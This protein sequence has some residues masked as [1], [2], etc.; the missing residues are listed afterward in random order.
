LSADPLRIGRAVSDG[1]TVMEYPLTELKGRLDELPDE[2]GCYVFKRRGKPLYVG[3]AKSLRK[4]VGQYFS[5]RSSGDPKAAAMLERATELELILTANETEALLLEMNLINKYRP[6]YNVSIH[7]FPYIKI[8]KEK[9]PR[10]FVTREGHDVRTGRYVGPFTDASAV[11][12]TVALT[13]RAFGLRTCAYDLDRNPP[14]RPCLD[15]EIGICLGPC[16]DA[17]TLE[18]YAV[19]VEKALKFITGR[20]SGVMRELEHRMAKAAA[21]L[22][23]EEAAKWRDVIKGLDRAVADQHAVAQRNVNADATACEVRA[24]KL[25]GVILRIREGKLVD[26]VTVATDAPAGNALEQFLLS[27]YG[28]GAEVPPKITVTRNFPGRNALAPSLAEKRGGTVA[29]FVPRWGEYAHLTNVAEKNL[30]YFIEAAEFSKARR[31]ELAAVFEE[32]AAATGAAEPPRRLEMVDIS[33]LGPKSV[34][35]SLVVFGGGIPDKNSYRRYRV[36]TISGQDDLA[37][38]AEVTKR[39]FAKVKNGEEQPPDLFLVDGGP[40]QLAAAAR[41]AAEAGCGEQTI[42]A[43]AKSPDRFFTRGAR[44]AAALSEA[45]TLFLARVRD[46]AHRFAVE[47]HRKVRR[48]G[49][50]KSLLDEVDGIGP[51]R[52]KALLKHFGSLKQIMSTS[53]EEL[54]RAPKM[55][56][57]AARALF[58]YLHGARKRGPWV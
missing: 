52:K 9:Y 54:A 50:S 43:F 30:R 17:V 57:R 58:D 2:P 33:N 25:Y 36:K 44:A 48:R 8:T 28:A 15:Y 29:I 38:V 39:R 35:G 46:E 6:K 19:L 45:A 40:N 14:R 21:S 7:G 1:L 27:H 32:L 23:F 42:A 3:K 51:V 16:A 5:G 24:G 53:A 37:A 12:R 41:A 49:V 47:Y 20:R 10:I 11:R 26:R 55:S 56:T 31:G 4:R 18:D 34:V 22:A 13:N